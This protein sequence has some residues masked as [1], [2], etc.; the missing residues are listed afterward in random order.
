MGQ[1]TG[2]RGLRELSQGW[3]RSGQAWG[4]PGA[5]PLAGK[6]TAFCKRQRSASA[7]S[8]E[9]KFSVSRGRRRRRRKGSAAP[10]SLACPG[11]AAQRKSPAGAHVP[12]GP[13]GAGLARNER[14]KIGTVTAGLEGRGNG[15]TATCRDTQRGASNT[16]VH[17][18]RVTMTSSAGYAWLGRRQAR[19]V[20]REGTGQPHGAAVAVSQPE[21]EEEGLSTHAR[22]YV[23][24]VRTYGPNGLQPH[25]R[26]QQQQQCQAGWRGQRLAPCLIN[27]DGAAHAPCQPGPA[28]LYVGSSMYSTTSKQRRMRECYTRALVVCS[29]P[30]AACAAQREVTRSLFRLAPPALA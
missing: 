13:G 29:V 5:R 26:Q 24:T 30:C 15:R 14:P 23:R 16:D 21:E 28:P 8:R 25:D 20:L 10:L 17:G 22:M 7:H 1:P 2:S 6:P 19:S 3:A 18:P 27:G 11:T 12:Y 4:R 9:G